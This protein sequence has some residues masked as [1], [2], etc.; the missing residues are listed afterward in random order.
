MTDGQYGAVVFDFKSPHDFVE[1][2]K[3]WFFFDREYVCLGT[4]IHA[5][6]FGFR[7]RSGDVPG[8]SPSVAT[9]VNQV[10]MRSEVTVS[11]NGAIAAMPRGSRELEDVKWVHQGNVGYIF[12][13]PATISLSHQAQEGRWSDITDEKNISDELVREEVFM[14]WFDHGK[15]PDNASY[16][17]IMVPNVT[18]EELD[19]TSKSNRNVEILANTSEMQAVRHSKLEL[20]QIAF[21]KAGQAD[22]SDDMVFGMDSQGMAMIKMK[23]NRIERLSVSDPSRKLSRIT[24][25]VSGIYD[26]KGDGFFT[27]PDE[28]KSNTLVLIDLPQGAYAG[29]SVTVA[30]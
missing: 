24:V 13:E 27:I 28:S 29:K 4:D 3:S 20:C 15:R 16:Q 26:S 2:K 10:L 6:R 23:G 18:A 9:T 21:Y 25:T 14:M 1:A 30:F 22:V 19:E 7:P 8:G 12:P 5:D 17:Y 11:Q